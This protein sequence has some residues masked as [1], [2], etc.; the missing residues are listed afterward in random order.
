MLTIPMVWQRV[1][2]RQLAMTSLISITL[3]WAPLL[4]FMEVGSK[5]FLSCQARW[6]R[7]LLQLLMGALLSSM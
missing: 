7:V 5:N 2:T 6:P 3:N 4:V 1:T